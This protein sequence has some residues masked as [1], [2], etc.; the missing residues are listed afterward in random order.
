ML[1]ILH[2]PKWCGDVEGGGGDGGGGGGDS[3]GGF[4]LFVCLFFSGVRGF[5][6]NDVFYGRFLHTLLP[7]YS[8]FTRIKAVPNRRIKTKRRTKRTRAKKL[9]EKG[10]K[11]S[12][13]KFT[14]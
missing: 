6:G 7:N 4:F 11:D 8:K 9:G 1:A 5:A 2:S 10:S 13:K 12:G 14:R 3:G